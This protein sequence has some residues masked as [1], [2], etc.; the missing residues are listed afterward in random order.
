MILL[1][2]HQSFAISCGFVAEGIEKEFMNNAKETQNENATKDNFITRAFENVRPTGKLKTCKE[3][4]I[5]EWN[6]DGARLVKSR[7]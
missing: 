7:F 2:F 5:F 3:S 6:N 4:S 1:K